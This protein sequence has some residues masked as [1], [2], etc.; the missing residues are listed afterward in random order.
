MQNKQSISF[1]I[2]ITVIVSFVV[3]FLF[4]SVLTTQL[5]YRNVTDIMQE[6]QQHSITQL[7]ESFDVFYQQLIYILIQLSEDST[8]KQYLTK[9]PE[10]SFEYYQMQRYVHDFLQAYIGFFPNSNIH[11]ILYGENGQTYTS[12]N[13]TL[14]LED[15]GI[16]EEDFIKKAEKNHRRLGVSYFHPGLTPNTADNEYMYIAHALYDPYRSRYYGTILIVIDESCFSRLYSDLVQDNTHF[17]VITEDGL[18][19][20]DSKRELLNS[21][22][23]ALLS[24]ARTDDDASL[25]YGGEKWISSAVY[26]GY[27]NFYILQLTKYSTITSRVSP[28]LMRIIELCC[29]AQ[30]LVTA[31]LVYLFKKITRPI[32]QLS[33]AMQNVS[34]RDLLYRPE[35]IQFKGCSEARLLGESFNEMFARLEYYTKTLM[36]EQAARHTAELNSLQHQIN[37]HFIYNTLTSIKYLSMAGQRDKVIT[38]INSLTK[39]LRKTLGDI[40]ETIPLSQELALL[41]DYFQIQQ[42]RYGDGIRLNLNVRDDCLAVPVPKFFLQPLVENSIFHGFS[43]NTPNGTIS[44]YACISGGQLKLE[45]MD[46]GIGIPPAILDHIMDV[47]RENTGQGL[48]KIGLKNIEDRIKMIYG[49]DYG[50]S[51]T[52]TSGYGTQVTISLPVTASGGGNIV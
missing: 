2:I 21:T 35:R 37:P 34:D 45:I 42:L 16:L 6:S 39:L 32:H 23:P 24:I 18:I 33:I 38:G 11:L 8:L 31:T 10:D 1:Q 28:S 13:E 29:L 43:T 51:I 44:I 26:N 22:D 7:N 46:N 20:S 50:L 27:F 3:L 12:Y 41:R 14:Y 9:E 25:I 40:R 15:T 19:I 4:F 36:Q 30:L 49:P 17:S 48:T 5:Y 47:S 52:S